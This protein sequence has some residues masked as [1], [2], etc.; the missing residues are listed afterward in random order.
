MIIIFPWSADAK[1]LGSKR[2]KNLIESF[3][4]TIFQ[5]FCLPHSLSAAQHSFWD[6]KRARGCYNKLQIDGIVD[7]MQ[8]AWGTHQS[9]LLNLMLEGTTR[10]TGGISWW[11]N[12]R[13]K[14]ILECFSLKLNVVPVRM[15]IWVG[16]MWCGYNMCVTGMF[17][18]YTLWHLL[19]GWSIYGFVE[20]DAKSIL[21]QQT[22]RKKKKTKYYKTKKHYKTKKY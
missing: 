17:S 20:N 10:W 22:M 19:R 9:T 1:S 21:T 11:E 3:A 12:K 18:I 5:C 15:I 2:V 14:H 4:L 7:V 8:H 13:R 16:W 6:W